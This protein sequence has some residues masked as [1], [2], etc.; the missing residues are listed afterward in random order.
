MT[1][2]RLTSN[3]LN[4]VGLAH[5]IFAQGTDNRTRARA[6]LGVVT[7][8]PSVTFAKKVLDAFKAANG[9]DPSPAEF[10]QAAGQRFDAAKYQPNFLIGLTGIVLVLDWDDQRTSHSGGLALECPA[11]DVY[12]ANVWRQWASPSD[13]SGWRKHGRDPL[14]VYDW[15]DRAFPSARSP[16]DVFPWGHYPNE[17]VGVDLLPDPVTGQYSEAQREAWVKLVRALSKLHGFPVYDRSVTTH[18]YA[19]PCE[20]GT[21]VRGGK[22]VGIHWDP[23][24]KVWHHPTMLQLA[25]GA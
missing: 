7:H 17:A 20:R 12:A 8:T 15:W 4:A 1:V 10:D 6:P 2:S 25:R 14:A 22:I 23:D 5:T 13:G 24:E 9:R 16:L 18:S 3:D 19:S 11:G 21:V